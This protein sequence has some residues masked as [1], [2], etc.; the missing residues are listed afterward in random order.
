MASNSSLA[1][2]AS[3]AALIALSTATNSRL[4]AF[5]AG[6][7]RFGF[8]VAF[9]MPAILPQEKRVSTKSE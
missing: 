1:A 3:S 5:C 9:A 4:I 2:R 6:V 8:G 7:L